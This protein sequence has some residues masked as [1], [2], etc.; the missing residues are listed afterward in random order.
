MTRR[1]PKSW[2]APQPRCLDRRIGEIETL[3]RGVAAWVQSRNEARVTVHW[4]FTSQDA[5]QKLACSYPKIKS[6]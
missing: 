1:W 2:G 3:R 4:R 5:R 6:G